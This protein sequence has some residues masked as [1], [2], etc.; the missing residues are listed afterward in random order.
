MRRTTGLPRRT[1]V[2]ADEWRTGLPLPEDVEHAAGD[3]PER[4]LE[5]WRLRP[6]RGL[7]TQSHHPCGRHYPSARMV[8]TDSQRLA[9]AGFAYTSALITSIPTNGWSPSTQA[10]CPGG[11]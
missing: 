11:I 5:V 1:A 4:Q 10:S 9:A 3:T 7:S 6:F 8:A 2:G